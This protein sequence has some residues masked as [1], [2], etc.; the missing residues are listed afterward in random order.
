MKNNILTLFFVFFLTDFS[1]AQIS[2][3]NNLRSN[4][5]DQLFGSPKPYSTPVNFTFVNNQNKA[6][7]IYIEMYAIHQLNNLPNLDSILTEA[8]QNLSYFVDSFK[9]DAIARRVDYLAI[10][11]IAPQFRINNNIPNGTNFTFKNKDLV[12]LKVNS[13]TL[14][15]KFYTLNNLDVFKK[16]TPNGLDKGEQNFPFV[17]NIVVNNLA[18]IKALPDTILANCIDIIRKDAKRYLTSSPFDQIANFSAA[19]DMKSVNSTPLGLNKIKRKNNYLGQKDQLEL[20]ANFGFRFLSGVPVPYAALGLLFHDRQ[21]IYSLAYEYNSFYSKDNLN[22]MTISSN[23]FLSIGVSQALKNKNLNEFHIVPT[24][25]FGKLIK[26]G[27]DWLPVDTYRFGMPA[28]QYGYLQFQPELYCGKYEGQSKS[29]VMPS[30]K[31]SI[32][33]F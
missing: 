23:D 10:P 29:Y 19:Y 7:K 24:F 5:E 9:N 16:Y 17:I 33:N 8:K 31:F 4:T 26:R 3:F 30:I 13:D 22:R 15:I 25:S 21:F 28:I 11:E 12:E 27:G 6:V 20:G 14:R 32:Y 2:N 18:D 1:N